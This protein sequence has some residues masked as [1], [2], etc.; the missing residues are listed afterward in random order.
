MAKDSFIS[1][2]KLLPI[3]S[4][5]TCS[6]MVTEVFQ[7]KTKKGSDFLALTLSD[8]TGSIKA[9]H[10]EANSELVAKLTKGSIFNFQCKLDSYDNALQLI[11]SSPKKLPE[12]PDLSDYVSSPKLPL[13]KIKEELFSIINTIADDDLRSLVLTALARPESEGF[14]TWPGASKIHHAYPGGL[15]EHTLSVTKLADFVSGQYKQELNRDLLLA[16]AILHDLG[17]CWEFSS[18]P[19][20]DYTIRGTLMGHLTMGALFLELVADSQPNFPQDKLLLMEH[21]L[22]AHHGQLENG[23]PVTPKIIEALVLNYLDELDARINRLG[24]FIQEETDGVK[25]TFTSYDKYSS[26]K[27]LSTPKWNE[28]KTAAKKS[29]PSSSPTKA[30]AISVDTYKL[31]PNTR[32]TFKG[33]S[34][35]NNL[36]N[37]ST[38]S[39][40]PESNSPENYP[41]ENYPPENFSPENYPPESY[42]PESN[43]PESFSGANNYDNFSIESEVPLDEYDFGIIFESPQDNDSSLINPGTGHQGLTKQIGPDVAVNGQ[44]KNSPPLAAQ[45]SVANEQSASQNSEPLSSPYT[46][47]ELSTLKEFQTSEPQGFKL[48]TGQ[49]LKTKAA[50]GSQTVDSTEPVQTF[51]SEAVNANTPAPEPTG[52]VGRSK[53]KKSEGPKEPSLLKRLF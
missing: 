9:K 35:D 33:R 39:C 15:L 26:T 28:E 45:G 51:S 6:L 11:V 21:I 42:P 3:G 10:W 50:P 36:N 47:V 4:N 16:G 32:V 5:F 24:K 48:A 37:Y 1:D 25:M 31:T 8:R 14:F 29:S 43:S 34:G 22:L 13:D 2:I 7:G 20:G 38:D 53:P 46:E 19:F 40:P 44:V 17:K 18:E 52:H 41:P 23:S 27:Y 30:P 49:E 12:P